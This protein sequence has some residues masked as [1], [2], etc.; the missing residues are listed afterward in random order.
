MVKEINFETARQV[1]LI[2]KMAL[3][4]II[5]EDCVII[6]KRLGKA[7]LLKATLTLQRAV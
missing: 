6:K 3:T 4:T 2:S 1:V 7:T 5:I